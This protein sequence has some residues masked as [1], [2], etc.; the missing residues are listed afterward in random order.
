M[1]TE[2]GS[3]FRAPPVNFYRA[4]RRKELQAIAQTVALTFMG[5]RAEN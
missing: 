3:N 1:L 4:I 5:T 2:S